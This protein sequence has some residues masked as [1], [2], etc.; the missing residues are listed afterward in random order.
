MRECC[1]VHSWLYVLR[2]LAELSPREEYE[3]RIAILV[4]AKALGFRRLQ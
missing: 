3:F 2:R 1:V 4:A